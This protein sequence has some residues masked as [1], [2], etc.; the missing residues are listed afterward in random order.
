MTEAKPADMPRITAYLYYE[1]LRGTVDWLVKAFGFQER[2][3]HAVTMPDGTL[4]HTEIQIGDLRCRRSQKT[5]A[6]RARVKAS[7][8]TYR[9]P[10]TCQF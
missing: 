9:T 6:Y 10:C 8:R 2:A 1:D 7:K 3:D 4:G 5:T